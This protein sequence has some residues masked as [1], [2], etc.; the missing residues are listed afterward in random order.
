MDKFQEMN[1]LQELYSKVAELNESIYGFRLFELSTHLL[2]TGSWQVEKQ[3]A[4]DFKKVEDNLDFILNK[5]EARTKE[6]YKEIKK[7]YHV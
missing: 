6:V 1:K 4:N 2:H 3:F 7:E 5:I